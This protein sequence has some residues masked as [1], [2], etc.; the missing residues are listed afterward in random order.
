[1]KHGI[2][3]AAVLIGV[4]ASG[5]ASLTPHD[6]AA[7]TPRFE[8]DKFFEGAVRSWGVIETRSGQPKSRLRAELHGRREGVDV[9]VTQDFTFEDGRTKQRVW[10]IRR[11]DEH[12]YAA[13]ADDVIGPAIGYA[14]GNAFHWTYTLQLRPRNALSRVRM[15][16]WMYLLDDGET[17]MNRVVIR[18]FGVTVAQ[19]TE[20]FRRVAGA[21]TPVSRPS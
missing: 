11:L 13:F 5:C 21:V 3:I 18:K 20:F 2:S 4:L 12:R 17:M 16:H 10:R 6:F 1:M 8:P 14:S 9:I 7:E 19:T 15:E